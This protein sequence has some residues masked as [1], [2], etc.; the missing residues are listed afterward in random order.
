MSER[1]MEAAVSL[2][3][4]DKGGVFAVVSCSCD[5]F[6]LI[7]DGRRRKI[8]KP[9]KKKL[10]HLK[11]IGELKVPMSE[12]VTNRRLRELLRGCSG[13]EGAGGGM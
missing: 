3:G 1:F 10:R 11:I 5:G 12:E 2:A 7:A 13:A 4:H 9:K 6:V 8:E